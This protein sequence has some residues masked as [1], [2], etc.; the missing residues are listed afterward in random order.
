MHV[1]CRVI[2]QHLTFSFTVLFEGVKALLIVIS[3][4]SDVTGGCFILSALLG[5]VTFLHTTSW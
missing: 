1:V 4:F 3:L 5:A 2:L